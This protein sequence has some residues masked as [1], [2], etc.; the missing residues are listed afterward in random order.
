MSSPAATNPQMEESKGTLVE[1]LVDCLAIRHKL[2]MN[3]SL[4]V[5]EW[6]EHALDFSSGLARLL[7]PRYF[8]VFNIYLFYLWATLEGLILIFCDAL[9]EELQLPLYRP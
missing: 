1:A 2:I 9:T 5:E 4:S 6:D 3:N 7:G 8:W